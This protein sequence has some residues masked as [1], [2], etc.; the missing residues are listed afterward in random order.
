MHATLVSEQYYDLELDVEVELIL[1]HDMVVSGIK[2]ILVLL[3][4]IADLEVWKP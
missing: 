3:V 2:N 1:L 4:C